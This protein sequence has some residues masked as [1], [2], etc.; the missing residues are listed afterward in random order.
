MGS[1]PAKVDK[2]LLQ[3]WVARLPAPQNE[4]L[5]GLIAALPESSVCLVDEAVKT[6]L[7]AVI[8]QHYKT[9]PEAIAMQAS[10]DVVPPT[11]KNHC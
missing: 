7:A 5:E 4:L 11:V 1:L 9:H 3:S 6:K 10:G 2:L 8:R